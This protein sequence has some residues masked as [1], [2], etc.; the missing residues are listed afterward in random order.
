MP[1]YIYDKLGIQ[2]QSSSSG[3]FTSFTAAG[4][5][6]TPQTISD[7]N[8]LSVLGGVGITTV[9]SATDTVTVK[10]AYDHEVT[11]GV[12]GSFDID[13]T[14][15]SKWNSNVKKIIIETSLRGTVSATTTAVRVFLNN[16]LTVTNY[17]RQAMIGLSNSSGFPAAND[18]QVFVTT[19][20]TSPA[21]FFNSGEVVIYDANNTAKAKN[22]ITR[23]IVRFDTSLNSRTDANGVSWTGVAAIT[24][25]QIRTANH[26]T[27]LFASTSSVRLIFVE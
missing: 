20:S 24:R 19:G 13:L 1:L 27:D 6:G 8:T 11:L 10:L 7:G 5:T 16:D 17:H 25:L 18:N 9:A 2:K 15:V 22:M 14:A 23:S 26:P 4:N 3:G 12:S 21:N